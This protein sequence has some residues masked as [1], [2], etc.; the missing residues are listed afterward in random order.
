MYWQL[1]KHVSTVI[2]IPL[3]MLNELTQ[4][5]KLSKIDPTPWLYIAL[6]QQALAEVCIHGVEPYRK[7]IFIITEE[8]IQVYVRHVYT[9]PC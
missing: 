3:M 6:G 8:M 1:G 9:P 7:Y 4:L 5:E 2:N